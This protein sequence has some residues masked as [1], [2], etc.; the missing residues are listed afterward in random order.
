MIIVA[1]SKGASAVS[2]ILNGFLFVA[3]SQK[4]WH[5]DLANFLCLCDYLRVL[6][7]YE[8]RV[9]PRATLEFA[10]SQLTLFCKRPDYHHMTFKNATHCFIYSKNVEQLPFLSFS[11]S[12]VFQTFPVLLSFQ[13]MC[14]SV[15]L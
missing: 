12:L 5:T 15:T 14:S 9:E 7:A 11:P 10:V 8:K 1:Q 4:I 2:D 13:V 3:S 6:I